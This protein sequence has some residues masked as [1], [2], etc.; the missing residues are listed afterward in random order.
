MRGQVDQGTPP[1]WRGRSC[2]QLFLREE[3]VDMKQGLRDDPVLL[4]LD[5]LFFRE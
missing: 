5:N 2:P 1:F 4:V 3:V